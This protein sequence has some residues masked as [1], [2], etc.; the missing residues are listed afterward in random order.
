MAGN[1]D[2]IREL[3]NREAD[4]LG[5]F[6]SLATDVIPN[7]GLTLNGVS[8]TSTATSAAQPV[9][10]PTDGYL[11]GISATVR[12][13]GATNDLIQAGMYGTLLRV[14]KDGNE[15]LF[16]TGQGSGYVPFVQLAPNA[17][18]FFRIRRAFKNASYW[19]V[20][21]QNQSAATQVCDIT[22]WSVGVA[23]KYF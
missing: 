16:T 8:V 7:F 2:L 17:Q 21:V 1:A 23:Q 19:Q 20:Y 6:L 11:V 22:F 12:G 9:Q 5:R 3:A 14:V 4:Q 18:P 15:E 10:W 13:S